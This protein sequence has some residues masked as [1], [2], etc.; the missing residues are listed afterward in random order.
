MLPAP[1]YTKLSREIIVELRLMAGKSDEST[2]QREFSS[3]LGY[4]FN[5][6]GKWE[7]GTT[8]FYWQDFTKVCDTLQI[9]W[10]K[11][12]EDA[13]LFR[14]TD[15]NEPLH[16][17][18]VLTQFLGPIE[19]DKLASILKRSRSSVQRLAHKQAKL[20]F[21]D[22]LRL[23]D[24]RPY[25]LQSWLGRFFDLNKFSSFAEKF[26]SEQLMFKGI[27]SVPWASSVNAALG[28]QGYQELPMHSDDWVAQQVGLRAEDVHIALEKLMEASAIYFNGTKYVGHFQEITMLKSPEFRRVTQY[29]NEAVAKSFKADRQTRPDPSRPS[30]SSTRIYPVSADASREIADAFV[31]FHHRIARIIKNDSGPKDHVRAI[32]FHCLDMSLLGERLAAPE[33]SPENSSKNSPKNLPDKQAQPSS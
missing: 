15:P 21:V 30:L 19:T 14:T 17:F 28:L 8:Q 23:I 7:S 5:Q 20:D 18:R 2:S 10:R 3:K 24:V 1:D 27:L 22:F 9:S 25:V 12:T 31:E 26:R 29:L 4:S 33:K 13:L 11:H 16:I 32:L 6:A